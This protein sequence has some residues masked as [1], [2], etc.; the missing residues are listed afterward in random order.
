M[1]HNVVHMGSTIVRSDAGIIAS[2]A[3][4][5]ITV[6]VIINV[7]TVMPATMGIAAKSDTTDTDG[8]NSGAINTKNNK[9]NN[10]A[11]SGTVAYTTASTLTAN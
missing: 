10:S 7:A 2:A 9:S 11:N 6:S 4:I 3:A 5:H 1:G 8:T